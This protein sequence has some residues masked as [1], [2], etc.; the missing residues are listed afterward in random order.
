ME[1]ITFRR[2]ILNSEIVERLEKIQQGIVP[3]GYKD[4]KVGVIPEHWK[5][6]KIESIST[7]NSGKYYPQK[8]D[9]EYMCI[10]LEHIEKDNGVLKGFVDSNQ[11]KSTKNIFDKGDILYG[12]LRPYLKKYYKPDFKGICSTEI[13]VLK[14]NSKK[15]IS[16]YL[17]YIIQTQKFDS[18]C[19]IST[20]SS[21]PRADWEYVGGSSFPFPPLEEQEEI[22]QTLSTWDKAIEKTEQLIQEKE[23][24]KKGLMQ[25]LLTGESRLPGFTG[26]WESKDLGKIS[27]VRGG[28]RIPKGHTLTQEANDHPYI[29][30]AD[31]G[32]NIVNPND[33][34]YVPLEILERIKNYKVSKDDIIISVAGTLGKINYISEDLDGANLTENADKITKIKENREFVFYV[35]K[36]NI[37]QRE[38]QKEMTTNAQPK[39]AL[40]KIRNFKIPVP[41]L[42][43][44]KAIAEILTTADRE[45]QLLNQLL[46]SKKEQKK[47]LMQLLL[48][49]IIRV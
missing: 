20:G 30:V 40:T 49:G 41:T 18:I 2:W 37:I 12:K 44:Q 33:I 5:V 38:I 9:A 27:E 4:T 29:T 1:L 3:E 21:M 23:I 35:M 25:Q 34:K 39:L 13:W 16:G 43:E 42:P 28:K 45:I 36:S 46:A 6:R 22:A 15:V 31:M 26:E 47:G 8:T 10:E 11:I 14:N 48:T 17:Y 19:N 24:Q 32:E 7:I